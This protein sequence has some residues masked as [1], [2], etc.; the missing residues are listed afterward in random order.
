MQS[1]EPAGGRAT[2]G[3]APPGPGDA[4]GRRSAPIPAFVNPEAGSGA[5]ALAALESD[6]RFAVRRVGPDEIADAIRQAAE[7]GATRVLVAGGDGTL[8]GGAEAAS[9]A[10]LE[11]ALLPAGTRNHFA[12]HHAIPTDPRGAL[13]LAATGQAAW[14][15][16][17]RVNGR[18]FLNTSSVG[19]YVPFVRE[20]ERLKP[21][22]GY[23]LASA[24]AALRLLADL[25]RY[26]LSLE[27][28]AGTEEFI[29]PLVFVGVGERALSPLR[30]RRLRPGGRM[31]L[32]VL[33]VASG[34][35]LRLL[36]RGLVALLRRTHAE[37][38]DGVSARV[39]ER[40]TL[41]LPER[42]APLATDGEILSFG[43]PLRYEYL[44]RALRV[45]IPG[46][47]SAE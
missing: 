3:E 44:P 21:Y 18:L 25:P 23:R 6:R 33:V 13:E 14:V 15:G 9:P 7:E 1:P 11:V 4:G 42:S 24:A 12:R 31:G 26:R 16:A 27:T 32:H 19:A 28:E 5:A 29:T 8:A 39:V 20:R 41:S 37:Q 30:L 35:P 38:I 46:A 40:F 45:V 47:R 10:G 34:S 17:G 36:L 2:A 22:L 43:P